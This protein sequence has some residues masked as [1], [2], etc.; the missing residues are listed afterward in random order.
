M[1]QPVGE[2][3]VVPVP[4]T[5]QYYLGNDASLYAFPESGWEF[6]EWRV[7]GS[8]YSSQAATTVTMDDNRTVQAIFGIDEPIFWTLTMAPPDGNGT[9]VPAPGDHTYENGTDATL[10]ATPDAGWEFTKWLVD[11]SYYSDSALTSI[12]MDSNRTVQ[13]VFDKIPEPHNRTLTMLQPFGSGTV[14]PV[15]GDHEYEYGTNVTLNATADPGWKFSKWLVD[16]ETEYF[17]AV[18]SITMLQ[19]VTVRAVFIE[20]PIS[21]NLT[22]LQPIGEGDVD[23]GVGVR[24]YANGT[25]VDLSAYPDSHNN[26]YFSEWL[27]DGEPYSNKANDTILMNKSRTVQAVFRQPDILLMLQPVGEGSVDPSPGPHPYIRGTNVTL[28]ATPDSGW[29]FVRWVVDGSNY[30]NDAKTTITMTGD[31]EAYAVF[32]DTPEP[33]NRTLTMLQPYGN[34]TVEPEPGTH[35]Y[36]FCTSVPVNATPDSGWYLTGWWV[37]T[38]LPG[39]DDPVFVPGTLTEIPMVANWT[40]QAVFN[41]PGNLTLTMKEPLGNGT[42]EPEPG[43]HEYAPGTSVF[44]NATPDAGWY[45]TGWWVEIDMSGLSFLWFFFGSEDSFFYSGELTEIPMIANLTLQA[46]FVDTPEP[47]NRTLTMLQPY[48]N[49]TVMPAPGVHEYEFGTSVP[50]NATPDTDW[51]LIGW[52]VGS[53]FPGYG[54]PIFV[55]GTL[56]G[57][58]IPMVANWTLQAVFVDTPEPGNLTLTMK[59]PL[60]N[61]TVEPAPG[62]HEYEYG[63]LVP[64][65]ATPDSGWYLTGWLVETDLP[66]YDEPFMY[67]GEVTEIPMVANWTL[68]AVFADT[69]EPG[70]RT[71]TMLQPYGNGT[72]EPVPGDHEYE[73]A[74]N[75]TLSAYPD[76]GRYFYGWWVDGILYSYNAVA[77][78]TMLRNVTVQAVFAD[79]P[80]PVNWTLTMETP[81][82]NG[83]VDP[84]PGDHKY[85]DGTNVTLAATPD[86]GWEFSKWLVDGD[87]FSRD[88]VTTITMDDNRTVRAVFTG[89]P[90]PGNRTLT[91][92]EPVGNGTVEPAPGAHEYEY[93]T[94]VPVHATPDTGW[95]FIAW[96]VDVDG[97]SH[98][99]YPALKDDGVLMHANWTLQA[100]FTDTEPGNRTLTMLPPEGNGT[101]EPVPGVHEHEFGSWALVTATP[102][103]G[104]YFSGWLV[105]A[106][107]LMQ[108]F[109][110]YE[111]VD[112]RYLPMI[113]NWTIQAVF[114]DSPEPGNRTLTMQEALGSGTVV[115]APGIHEY[116]FGTTATLH[117]IP[118]AGWEFSKWLVDRGDYSG[119]PETTILMHKNRTA[120]AVFTETPAPTPTP[121]PT[122]T[123]APKPPKDPGSRTIRGHTPTAP[124]ANFTANVTGGF[125]PL[126]IQFTDTSK[127]LP[128]VWFWDF[129][130]GSTSTLQHPDHTY[131]APGNY[132]VSLEVKNSV[133]SDTE[134]KTDYII[135]SEPTPTPELPDDEGELEV[136]PLWWIIVVLLAILIAAGILYYRHHTP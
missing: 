16:N 53:D 23:P 135:V 19:N 11:G 89:T 85:R 26:W 8:H 30:S 41:E 39:Y 7:D 27:V 55:P 100:V 48:G 83:T 88:A 102:D 67:P 6:Y 34:G 64:V 75:V 84:I 80:E 69:P 129:G 22:M 93:S 36:A 49:G 44:V 111:G 42:I 37:E 94:F 20:T 106:E 128:V 54:D 17:D 86:T 136:I 56:T 14:E 101:V 118:D 92:K 38:D 59:E 51:Y 24:K 3:T 112:T 98:G 43:V 121:T 91:M 90:E 13:A 131:A 2:G 29:H 62:D 130:D 58:Q 110:P 120:Q 95:Y 45:L 15:P 78:I 1:E 32:A 82:G 87:E 72:V 77:S 74:T 50:V 18:T 115:P 73:Y 109:Y 63:S 124:I 35:E 134:T 52:R 68:Q 40:L 33:G 57:I 21:W 28:N 99:I 10:N 108:G 65:N 5:H 133:A 122:P 71:L 105:D 117:A 4:G 107:G 132:T 81:L 127:G 46:V 76:T 70:N 113:T 104:W 96:L 47:G 103:A 9:I 119:D 12:T 125:A 31:R 123:P 79:S 116:P 60:G 25:T 61:G 114:T 66:G 97:I 126:A